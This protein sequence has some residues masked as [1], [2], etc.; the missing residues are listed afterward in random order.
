M[1][2]LS[3]L[4]SSVVVNQSLR[5]EKTIFMKGLDGRTTIHRVSDDM[6]IWEIL[7]DRM[8]GLNMVISFNGKLV[9]VHDTMRDVGIGHDCTLRCT[10]RLRG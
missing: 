9:G 1:I 7:D 4:R 6:M 8:F 3:G 5:V 10:G 2:R